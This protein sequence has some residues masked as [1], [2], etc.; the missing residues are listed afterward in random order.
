MERRIM[1]KISEIK[2][3]REMISIINDKYCELGG[4]EDLFYELITSK[5]DELLEE[6][7]DHI[8]GKTIIYNRKR[9]IVE[10]IF[11]AGDGLDI[12]ANIRREKKVIDVP[13]EDLL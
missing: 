1:R 5:R 8:K 3:V 12:Y 13:I 10:A 4:M 6:L 9:W 11:F 2:K 7:G